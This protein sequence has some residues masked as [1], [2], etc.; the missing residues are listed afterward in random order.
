MYKYVQCTSKFKICCEGSLLVAHPLEIMQILLMSTSG[1]W[2]EEQP[3]CP[4][5]GPQF[6]PPA[7]GLAGY[8][9][10]Y[11]APGLP[12]FLFTIMDTVE[13]RS[14]ARVRAK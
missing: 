8:G 1:G 14:S 12:Q 13:V 3:G 10:S 11:L 5:D 9:E 7:P 4:R 2:T 6:P